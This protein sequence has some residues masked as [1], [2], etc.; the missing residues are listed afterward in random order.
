MQGYL[1]AISVPAIAFVVYL[2]IAIVKYAVGENEKF[3][4]FIPLIA[5]I[6]GVIFGIVCFY[7][8]PSIIPADNVVVAIVLG[9][10]SGL[11]ATATDQIFKQL[12]KKKSDNGEK[13][14]TTVDDKEDKDDKIDNPN[15]QKDGDEK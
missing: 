2:V 12:G 15:E 3:K 6:L 7:L 5:M 1:N 8:L 4:R 14:E 10:A 13:D 11:T 9:G